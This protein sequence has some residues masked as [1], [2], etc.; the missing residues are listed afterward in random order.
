M[1]MRHLTDDRLVVTK[2]VRAFDGEQA[3]LGS[4]WSDVGAGSRRFSPAP[5]SLLIGRVTACLRSSQ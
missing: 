4:D 2:R 1:A 5:R 3:W